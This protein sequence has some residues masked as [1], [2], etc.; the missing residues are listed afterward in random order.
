MCEMFIGLPHREWSSEADKTLCEQFMEYVLFSGKFGHKRTTDAD[1]SENAFTYAST[2]KMAL[3]LLQKQGRSNWNAAK[4][5]RILR[6]FA[7]TY[8]LLRYLRKGLKRDNAI[9]KI[10]AE[11][12]AAKKRNAMFE[13]LGINTA[14]KGTV[15]YEDGKYIKKG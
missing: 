8:Q 11:Y 10:K 9:S 5:H 15:V 7:W 13:A 14:A 3:K 4:K 12:T 1:I 6:P 2:P